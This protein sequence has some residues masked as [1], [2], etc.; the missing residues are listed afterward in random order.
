P[1]REETYHHLMRLY[2]QLGDRASVARIYQTCAAVLG[3]ELGLE[4]GPATAQAYSTFIAQAANWDFSSETIADS[5]ERKT[6][7]NLPAYLTSFVGR[8]QEVDQLTGLLSR[9]RLVTL[10]GPGGIGKTRLALD[11]A[12][13]LLAGYPDGIYMVDLAPVQDPE[14]IVAAIMDALQASDDV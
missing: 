2:A 3:Q 10:S 12:R 8:E 6:P 5:S 4:P 7:H 14:M 1:T 9:H 11:T 13:N